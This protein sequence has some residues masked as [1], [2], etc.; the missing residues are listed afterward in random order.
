MKIDI[1]FFFFNFFPDIKPWRRKKE[2]TTRIHFRMD[3][4]EPEVD[5][6]SAEVR[7]L[8]APVPGKDSI[9]VR[10]YQILGTRRRRFVG[11]KRLYT[12]R[13][14]PKWNQFEVTGT[15]QRWINGERNLGLDIECSNC[16]G[17]FK[18]LQANL[19][20]LAYTEP[21]RRKRSVGLS[22]CKDTTSK[23]QKC[24]RHEM[25]VTFD[26]LNVPQMDAIVEPK[27]YE[28][29]YCKGRCPPNYNYATN[30]SRIQSLV[31]KIDNTKPRACCAPS[32]L[33]SLDILRVDPKN[34]SSL[35]VEKWENMVV[36]E[37]ACS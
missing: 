3:G 26:K 11:Q 19:S 35:T 17:P 12:S 33:K 4:I 23:K 8:T 28:A 16:E 15:A 1:N 25:E 37:C 9:E 13:I 34:S 30:H 14:D 5:L 6:E 18:L 32:K 22:T 31:H 21:R 36:L 10:L 2:N 27:F 20:L 7:L 24:C 29:G